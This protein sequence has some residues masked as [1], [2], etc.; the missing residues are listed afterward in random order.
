MNKILKA[1]LVF[2]LLLFVTFSCRNQSDE[3][4]PMYL[5]S[6]V[7]TQVEHSNLMISIPPD[8]KII[9]RQGPDFSVYYIYPSDTTLKT[10]FTAGLYLGNNPSNFPAKKANCKEETIKGKVFNIDQNWMM[11]NCEEVYSIQTMIENKYSEGW[12]DKIHAFGNANSKS[13][14]TKILAIFSTLTKK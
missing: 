8:Y 4:N 6:L 1:I 5:K 7:K 12:N 13:D 11:Y 3:I 14:I 10:K 2:I 9:E